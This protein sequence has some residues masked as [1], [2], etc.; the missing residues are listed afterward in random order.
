M[1]RNRN[2]EEKQTQNL[3]LRDYSLPAAATTIR[4]IASL[5]GFTDF[6]KMSLQNLFES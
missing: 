5:L 3:S 2:K 1:A 6:V 4:L